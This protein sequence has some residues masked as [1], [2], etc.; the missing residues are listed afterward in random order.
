[1]HKW[2]WISS[3]EKLT[4]GGVGWL[5]RI[6]HLEPE[7]RRVA[8][9]EFA[10]ATP[11]PWLQGSEDATGERVRGREISP[12]LQPAS[13]GGPQG[14]VEMLL[15]REPRLENEAAAVGA[16]EIVYMQL[17]KPTTGQKP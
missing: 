12:W 13:W 8:R 3:V 17:C 9:Q 5:R 6:F 2:I 7:T 14:G 15:R 10:R 16:R 11:N 1:M 4:L